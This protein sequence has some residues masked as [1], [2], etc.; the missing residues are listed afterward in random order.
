MPL[1][2]LRFCENRSMKWYFV[3]LLRSIVISW[4]ALPQT[5][6]LVACDSDSASRAV[7]ELAFRFMPKESQE[8]ILS[9]L[10]NHPH[11]DDILKGA[12]L[13]LVNEAN[14]TEAHHILGAAAAWPA[15]KG[16]V[17]NHK[18][19]VF[20]VLGEK[21]QKGDRGYEI[22]LS[23]KDLNVDADLMEA[24]KWNLLNALDYHLKV[25][26]SSASSDSDKAKSLCWIM[27]LV[28]DGHNPC[29]VATFSSAKCLQASGWGESIKI[30]GHGSL[31]KFWIQAFESAAADLMALSDK[32]C[33][34][35][36]QQLHFKNRQ[37]KSDN[38]FIYPPLWLISSAEH[39]D[40]FVYAQEV[41]SQ[42]EELCV[43][44]SEMP[45][46]I[47]SDTYCLNSHLIGKMQLQLASYRCNRMLSEKYI[48]GSLLDDGRG[49]KSSKD[50]A[51]GSSV[52]S[53]FD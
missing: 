4:L 6:S 23:R 9:I 43:S 35:L 50:A 26:N 46:V 34:E 21:T 14:E 29:N 44:D 25:F 42:I 5:G 47:C 51:K 53:L 24:R 36:L 20:R 1:K 40:T 12:S 2:N 3:Q 33:R 17:L 38:D 31:R 10:E 28:S 27:H 22:I 11:Y 45:I 48:R 52:D 30:K 7:G 8:S 49:L 16:G 19:E 18:I 37:G 15:H 32:E 39:A 41:R 13:R